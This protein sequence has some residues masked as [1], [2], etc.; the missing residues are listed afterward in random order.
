MPYFRIPAQGATCPDQGRRT[1]LENKR[2][3]GRLWRMIEMW[4]KTVRYAKDNG[5]EV[6]FENEFI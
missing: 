4:E 6:S 5:E 1:A 2:T 3:I